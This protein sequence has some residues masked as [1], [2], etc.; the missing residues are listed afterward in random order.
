MGV[1]KTIVSDR[2]KV[3]V[4]QFWQE[5]FRLQQT[6]LHLSIAYHPQSDDQT[7][8][9]N[10]SLESYLRCMTG[11]KPQEW[12]LWILLAEWWYNSNWHSTIGVTPYEVVYVQPPSLH[13]PYVARDCAVEVV[14]RSLQAREECIEMLRYHLTHAQQRMKKQANKLEVTSSLRWA[15]G[16]MSRYSLIDSILLPSEGTRNWD[17]KFLDL[18][19]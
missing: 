19:L 7:K 11:E 8:V 4:S 13:I 6:A 2:D 15:L 16:F 9:V 18:F 5:L 17:K 12:S 10:R 14:D 1:P 3:F